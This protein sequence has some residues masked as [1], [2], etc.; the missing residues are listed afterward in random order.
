MNFHP[1][2]I[3]VMNPNQIGTSS[4]FFEYILGAVL[5]EPVP[6]YTLNAEVSFIRGS[7]RKGKITDKIGE[8]RR[9]K[10]EA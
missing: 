6:A 3:R 5:S 4:L 9:S 7:S 1:G 10:Q 2:L 8:E